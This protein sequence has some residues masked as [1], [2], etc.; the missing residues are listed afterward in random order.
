MKFLDFSETKLSLGRPIGSYLKVQKIYSS[1]IRSKKFQISKLMNSEKKLLNVGCGPNPTKNFINLDYLWVPGVDICWDITKGI[2]LESETMEGIYTEHCLEHISFLECQEAI[3]DFYRILKPKGIVRIIV[4]DGELYIDLYTR[5]KK[6]ENVKFPYVSDEEK[7]NGFTPIMPVNRIF[8]EHGHL[9]A[10]D[11]ETL[12]MLL[13]NA[14]FTNIKKES[15]MQ[16]RTDS[17][18]ID[19][20]SRK[21]ESLYIEAE[22]QV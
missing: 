2:P 3:K 5:S 14:G 1:L 7:Q 13:K 15:Y 4:P 22:K 10:Y 11:A 18:L 17:L 12:T 20:E 6:G 16:G 8:R 21:I 9:F 19:T